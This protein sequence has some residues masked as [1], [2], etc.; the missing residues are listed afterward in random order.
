M[1]IV[2]GLGKLVKPFVNVPSWMGWKDLK[3]TGTNIKDTAK[4]LLETEKAQR[5]ETFQQAVARFGL[6]PEQLAQKQ[7]DYLNAALLYSGIGIA[8]FLYAVYLFI[9]GHLAAGFLTLV[10]TVLAAVLAFRQHFFYYQIKR[11][12]LGCTIKEWFRDLIH[13]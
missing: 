7:K 12:K 10:L 6:N 3:S 8:L 13:L 11:H 9:F 2:R 5:T 1:K 4:A